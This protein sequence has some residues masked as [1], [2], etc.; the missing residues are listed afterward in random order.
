[1]ISKN[2]SREKVLKR[3]SYELGIVAYACK[4]NTP[5]AKIVGL[6]QFCGQA[7]LHRELQGILRLF[8]ENISKTI[9]PVKDK[10]INYESRIEKKHSVIFT[11]LL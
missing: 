9:H 3:T 6:Q 8:T 4:L 2:F 11:W 1:M 7:G 5:K 10:R